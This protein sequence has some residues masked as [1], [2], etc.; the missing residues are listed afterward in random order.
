VYAGP[1]GN[2]RQPEAISL[3]GKR[4]K[5]TKVVSNRRPVASC[6]NAH[7]PDDSDR[8]RLC[9]DVKHVGDNHE[10][11]APCSRPHTDE[12]LVRVSDPRSI[13]TMTF[14]FLQASGSRRCISDIVCN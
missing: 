14:Y 7:R 10:S 4:T 3:K 5:K 11:K 2:G 9:T 12:S 8:L 13:S 1:V 6:T